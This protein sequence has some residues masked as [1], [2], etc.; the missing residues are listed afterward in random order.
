MKLAQKSNG[1]ITAIGG[2]GARV[3]R[4]QEHEYVA[5]SLESKL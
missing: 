1:T 2:D 5:G 3:V 4:K